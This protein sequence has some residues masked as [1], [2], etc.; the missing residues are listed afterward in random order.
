MISYRVVAPYVTLK[1][2][3]LAG[4]PVVRGFFGGAIVEVADEEQAR[5]QADL[6]LLEEFTPPVA[7]GPEAPPA[8][9][10]PA[11]NASLEAWATYALESGQASED[12]VKGLTRDELRELY[13]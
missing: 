6:G 10:R 8:V 3:D 7:A 11:G 9:E 12:E 13:G 1:V 5:A 2:K 4:S